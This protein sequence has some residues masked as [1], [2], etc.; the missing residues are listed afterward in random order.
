MK[1]LI[2]CLMTLNAQNLFASQ[3]E[4]PFKEPTILI[5]SSTTKGVV[6]V[7]LTASK[8]KVQLI[9][10][11]FTEV[12]AYNDM[13]PGPTI[14]VFEGDQVIVHFKN[15]LP[16]P[17]T[18]HWHGLHVPSDQDGGPM[19]LVLPGASRVYSYTIPFGSAG[20]YWYHPH[21]HGLTANQV[22]MGLT[23]AFIVRAAN[24]PLPRG[25]PE[26]LVTLT[27]N[28]FDGNS[29]ITPSTKMDKMMGR[30]GNVIFVNGQRSPTLNVRSGETHRFRILN[31]SSARYYL[32]NLPNH[33][34]LQ[35][36]TDGGLFEK[37]VSYSQILL[38]PAERVEVLITFNNSPGSSVEMQSLP[39][40]RGGMG[41]KKTPLFRVQYSNELPATPPTIPNVLRP[42]DPIDTQVAVERT[43][44]FTEDM[45]NLDFRINDQKFDMN[46]VD[47]VAK[48]GTVEI[49]NIK[50]DGDMDHPFHLHG[51][52]FQV[53]NHNGAPS[54]YVTWKDTVN[55]P[56]GQTA[57]FAVKFDNYRGIRMYHCHI[58]DHEDLG[59]MGTLEVK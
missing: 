49:W 56:K 54:P 31:A 3:M 57:R 55:V 17:T 47:T 15:L 2:L 18:V 52:Q 41:S 44:T 38:A 33:S 46:R 29:Q 9:D 21:P 32:L 51:F 25:I 42:I 6:E 5:N 45:K 28:R 24:E 1:F 11:K 22:A 34:L 8:T 12:Y 37:P 35:I 14:E 4:V 27:D 50:N 7:Q 19:D 30:E 40:D 23:G 43:F 16:E 20:T 39:Y 53:L 58:L 36:G 59:M 26:H 13:V 10:G 48:L